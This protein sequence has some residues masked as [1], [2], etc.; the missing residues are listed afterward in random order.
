M[1]L[2]IA[3]RSEMLKS[4]RT[5]SFFLALTGAAIIPAILLLNI[6]T[7]GSDLAVMQ[8]DPL[9]ELF[10]LGAERDGIVFFPVFVILVCT[11]LPQ[12]EYRNNTWK[13]VFAAPQAKG[14]T[15]LAKFININ[16]LMLVYLAASLVFMG[17]VV[18]ATHFYEPKLD[19]LHQPFDVAVV[20]TR[21]ANTYLSM[22]AV[23]AFQFWLG[24]RFRNFIV[25]TAAGFVLW[26]TGMILALEYH[27]SVVDF[28]PYSFQ[29]FPFASQYY[30]RV[31]QMVWL[32]A[33][34]AGLFL[35]LGFLD[36]RR[37]KV[38]A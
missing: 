16:I 18:A 4:R 5:A 1:K 3:L 21:T 33:G 29:L 25:P 28:Y 2:L 20:L 9:N 35:L 24:L 11:L 31:A 7:G 37:R 26:V 17:L 15:F 13:Q 19:L 22:L 36:F 10:K 12:I 8:Q 38:T 6:L 23:C 30:T 32:S 34:Y 27:S 14:N